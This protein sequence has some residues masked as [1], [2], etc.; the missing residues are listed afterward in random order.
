M[1]SIGHIHLPEPIAGWEPKFPQTR[2]STKRMFIHDHSNA[3]L[4]LLKQSF[5]QVIGKQKT[6]PRAEKHLSISSSVHSWAGTSIK[7]FQ[8]SCNMFRSDKLLGFFKLALCIFQT[9][10]VIYN[11]SDIST[12]TMA[13]LL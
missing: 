3:R 13:L 10:A 1:T 2:L 5:Y 8:S 7:K 11:K 9:L 12:L 4:D 6:P